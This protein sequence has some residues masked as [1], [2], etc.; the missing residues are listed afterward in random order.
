MTHR[1]RKTTCCPP[2]REVWMTGFIETPAGKVPRIGTCLTIHDVLG[3]L[4]VRFAVGRHNYTIP[5][6]L[7]A[8]GEPTAESPVF[9]SANYKL[10]FD[11]LRNALDGTNGWVMVLDTQGINVWCAASKGTFGTGEIV[12]RVQQTKLD[13]VVNHRKLIVPQLGAPGVS[14]TDVAKQCGFSVLYGPVRAED[15]PFFLK[16]NFTST[17]PM[18]RVRFALRD[19]IAVI[20]VELIIWFKQALILAAALALLSGFSRDGYSL[21][22]APHAFGLVFI[23]WLTGG[24]LVPLFLPFI[25][26]RA[27]S[28]KGVWVGLGLWSVLGTARLMGTAPLIELGWGL[29]LTS[30]VSFMALNFTGTSTYTSVSGVKK[31][32]KIAMPLQLIATLS[33]TVL[34][35]LGGLS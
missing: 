2:K 3:A 33:G 19:R 5:P 27:F 16:N 14:A 6:G 34:I 11:H 20:P 13:Q 28:L 32:M 12:N 1:C 31:E 9:V 18:R 22:H 15:I 10:S 4:K 8:F 7:Y 21:T 29:I 26:S 23:A 17:P 30:I 24:A 25:P 35:I